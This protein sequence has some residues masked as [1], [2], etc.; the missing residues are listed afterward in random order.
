MPPLKKTMNT[1]H[2]LDDETRDDNRSVV[3]HN[4]VKIRAMGQ[5]NQW[6]DCEQIENGDVDFSFLKDEEKVWK[7]AEMEHRRW[8]ATKYYYGWEYNEERRTELKQHNSLL[9]FEKLDHGTKKYDYDQIKE[10]KEVWEV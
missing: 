2:L 8:M 9:E 5:L 1:W 7:L 6:Q 3:E 4:F 10:L